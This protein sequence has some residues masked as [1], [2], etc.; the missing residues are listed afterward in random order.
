[1]LASRPPLTWSSVSLPGITAK[2]VFLLFFGNNAFEDDKKKRYVNF[3]AFYNL[4]VAKELDMTFTE[5]H[6]APPV[7]FSNLYENN[8]LEVVDYA[9]FSQRTCSFRHPIS[10]PFM[11]K[12][13]DCVMKERI[14]WVSPAEFIIDRELTLQGIPLASSF[15]PQVLY[16]IRESDEGTEI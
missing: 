13:C 9:D 8:K 16:I 7:Y 11:P 4:T 3:S 10:E 15:S 1:M 12:T 6:P 5:I 2:E 14:H